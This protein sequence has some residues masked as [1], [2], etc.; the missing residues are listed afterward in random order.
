MT[1][2]RVPLLT[3]RKDLLQKIQCA[4]VLL[5]FLWTWNP[6]HRETT[7]KLCDFLYEGLISRNNKSTLFLHSCDWGF[8]PYISLMQIS[9]NK[10]SS[11]L[12]NCSKEFGK[13]HYFSI[14]KGTVALLTYYRGKE[15]LFI[16]WF[17]IVSG[18]IFAEQIYSDMAH[19]HWWG[20]KI[21][22][23]RAAPIRIP[24]PSLLEIKK[25][26]R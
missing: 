14:S 3:K 18:I 16:P 12:Y 11:G 1:L 9:W 2:G 25:E 24:C 22:G 20:F 23:K 6:D 8:K 21:A 7:M 17:T 26:A 4:S 13:R 10:H 5:L 19:V 15:H